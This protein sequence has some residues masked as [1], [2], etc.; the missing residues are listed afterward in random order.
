[1]S[2]RAGIVPLEGRLSVAPLVRQERTTMSSTSAPNR[3]TFRAGRFPCTIQAK[4]PG[5]ERPLTWL[6]VSVGPLRR[7][8]GR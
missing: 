4:T 2:E 7:P 8:Q 1:M 3:R 6:A 5:R